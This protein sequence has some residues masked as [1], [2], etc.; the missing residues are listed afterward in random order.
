MVME[1][2]LR[3]K[4]VLDQAGCDLIFHDCGELIDPMVA[5]SPVVFIP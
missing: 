3:V 5:D 2:N 4:A 1:P